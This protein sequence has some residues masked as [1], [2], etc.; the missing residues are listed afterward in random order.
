MKVMQNWLP[1]VVR[2]I[3]LTVLLAIMAPGLSTPL[4]AADPSLAEK[5]SE[6]VKD[7]TEATSEGVESMMQK[8]DE[9]SLSNRSPEQI[10][11]LV[12][13]AFLV[14]SMIGFLT[15]LKN[16]GLGRI[17]RFLLGLAGAFVGTMVVAVFGLNFGWG[18]AVISYEELLFS[19]VG[20][21]LL[22]ALGR[23]I[24]KSMSGKGKDKPDK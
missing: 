22:V 8:I 1:A 16:T 15:R 19:F 4:S 17:G 10:G 21:I 14:G 6:T 20:A 24:S 11:G 23:Y 5:T 18:I 13:L 7:A 2:L 3:A 9:S 12:I